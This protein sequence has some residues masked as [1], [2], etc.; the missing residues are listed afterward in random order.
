RSTRLTLPT[1]IPTTVEANDIILQD[2]IQLSLAE[3]KGRDELET[4][5]NVQNV[6]EHLIAEKI[7]KLV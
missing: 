2:T 5:Q 1:P 3:K 7:E 4:Q 6:K